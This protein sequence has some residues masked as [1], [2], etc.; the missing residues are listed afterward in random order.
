M[1][2]W[3]TLLE[4]CKIEIEKLGFEWIDCTHTNS[5]KRPTIRLYIDRKDAGFT[6][7]DATVATK[8]LLTWFT[9]RLPDEMNFQLEVSSPGIDRP[10]HHLWQFQKNINRLIQIVY[11]QDGITLEYTGCIVSA[12]EDS[13]VLKNGK[14]LRK[15]SIQS[16]KEGKIMF[17][18]VTNKLAKGK[19]R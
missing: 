19:S 10:L 16:I 15:F 18:N 2:D 6:I 14:E 9:V 1:I 12:D 5:T 13:I 17:Q 4:E 11:E 3:D 7:D 8:H